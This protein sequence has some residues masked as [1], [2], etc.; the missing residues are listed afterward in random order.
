MTEFEDDL[1]VV[2]SFN[3][4]EDSESGGFGGGEW[5]VTFGGDHIKLE[6]YLKTSED[7]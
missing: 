1:V 7:V 2:F 5:L 3:E 4:V 6:T